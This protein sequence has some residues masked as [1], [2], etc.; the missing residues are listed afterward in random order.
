VTPVDNTIHAGHSIVSVSCDRTGSQLIRV[1]LD[2]CV[3][4]SGLSSPVS[5]LTYNLPVHYSV[6]QGS[7]PR[8]LE[9]TTYTKD[10][11]AKDMTD[12]QNR[13]DERSD[14]MLTTLDNKRQLLVKRN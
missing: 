7:V 4:L 9:F 1:L 5:R 12:L 14:C 3:A 13:D 11:G 8:P 2:E 6:R 10:Q